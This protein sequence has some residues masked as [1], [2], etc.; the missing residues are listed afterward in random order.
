MIYN[1]KNFN[2]IAEYVLHVS[3]QNIFFLCSDLKY[4]YA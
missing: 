2:I 3:C 1:E 4:C